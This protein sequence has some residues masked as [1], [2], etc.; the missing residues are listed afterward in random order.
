MR[1]AIVALMTLAFAACTK[2]PAQGAPPAAP[3]GPAPVAPPAKPHESLPALPPNTAATIYDLEV[4]LQDQAGRT[5]KLDL[6]RGHPVL[7]S[8][9]YGSCPAACP[10]LIS[11]LKN[12]VATIPESTRADL[13]VLLVSF[14]PDG[15]NV[16]HLQE[17]ITAHGVDQTRWTMARTDPDRVRELAAVLGIKY[18]KLPD[19]SFNHSSVV[20]L[21]DRQGRITTRL[22]GL[23]QPPDPIVAA[24]GA[25]AQR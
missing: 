8:M 10:L 16:A 14:D 22:E 5:V 13:R 7:I 21:L 6:Y 24:L 19:G 20:T 9:F 1:I 12:I 25:L 15:D 17:L 11:D 23:K 4:P 18:R 2:P 3:A